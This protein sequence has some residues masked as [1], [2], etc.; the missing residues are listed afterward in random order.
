MLKFN[1]SNIAIVYTSERSPL[2]PRCAYIISDLEVRVTVESVY[3]NGKSTVGRDQQRLERQRRVQVARDECL[4][5]RHEA[6]DERSE[7]VCER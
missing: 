6:I 4:R 2:I 1:W 7:G 3:D 5:R